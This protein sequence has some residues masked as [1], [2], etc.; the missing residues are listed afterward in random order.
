MHSLRRSVVRLRRAACICLRCALCFVRSG[1]HSFGPLNWGPEP[2]P[3]AADNARHYELMARQIEYPKVAAPENPAAAD[4]LPPRTLD[5]PGELQYWDMSLEEALRIA[6]ANSTVIHDVGGR[7]VNAAATTPTS[8]NPAIVDSD[9]RGGVEAAL[10][11]FDA[12]LAIATTWNKDD[13]VYN[14]ILTT[15]GTGSQADRALGSIELSKINATGTQ[16]KV[17]NVTNYV[18]FSS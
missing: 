13:R 14:S 18:A 9:P 5:K 15:L 3:D 1:A 17:R 7:V 16:V 10:S 4:T 6:L 2:K 12:Q 11:A 8:M